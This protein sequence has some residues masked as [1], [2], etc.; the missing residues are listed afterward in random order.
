MTFFGGEKML[1]TLWLHR[2]LSCLLQFHFPFQ[3]FLLFTCVFTDN[4]FCH[5]N[6][7]VQRHGRKV[8]MFRRVY[9]PGCVEAANVSL[10]SS[11]HHCFACR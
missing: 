5:L 6:T 4:P 8:E 9:V 2:T 7:T 1:E 11:H 10:S 3:T